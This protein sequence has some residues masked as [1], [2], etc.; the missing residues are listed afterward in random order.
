MK[1]RRNHQQSACRSAWE[2]LIHK[3]LRIRVFGLPQWTRAIVRGARSRRL[4]IGKRGSPFVGFESAPGKQRTSGIHPSFDLVFD[5][6]HSI[7]NDVR[8]AR[9]ATNDDLDHFGR[10]GGHFHDR[11][12]TGRHDQG[13]AVS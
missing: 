7:L 9:G 12:C 1:T 11:R 3:S 8:T 2:Q 5:W 13:A 4:S 6:R 10:R